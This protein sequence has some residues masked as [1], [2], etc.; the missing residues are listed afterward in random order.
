[1]SGKLS[2]R[3]IGCNDPE[4]PALALGT[5][6]LSAYYGA[7]DDDKTRFKFLDRAY[8]LGATLW[9]TAEIYSDS[10]ELLGKWFKRTG[11]RGEIFLITKVRCSCLSKRAWAMLFKFICDGDG[12]NQ[13]VV[14]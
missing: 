12:A 2:T 4:V 6:G 8:E 7:I 9:D 10:E 14:W 3:R 1:M 11:K 13:S 5:M